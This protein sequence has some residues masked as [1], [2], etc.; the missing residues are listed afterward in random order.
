MRAERGLVSSCSV[1]KARAVPGECEG[2]VGLS[3]LSSCWGRCVERNGVT[4]GSG[5]GDSEGRGGDEVNF[6]LRDIYPLFCSPSVFP[7][8]PLI[9]FSTTYSPYCPVSSCAQKHR[10][11][12]FGAHCRG[13]RAGG[14]GAVDQVSGWI[15]GRRVSPARC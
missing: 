11:C 3:D 1:P 14:P 7:R 12:A 5:E 2:S 15:M 10:Q 6:I 8:T 4:A 13:R 9:Q